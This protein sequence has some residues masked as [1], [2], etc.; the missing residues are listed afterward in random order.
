MRTYYLDMDERLTSATRFE[1]VYISV[2]PSR[3][4]YDKRLLTI[5]ASGAFI[6]HG[7]GL[8]VHG[9]SKLTTT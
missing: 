3:H 2:Q 6:C 4:T 7:F 9:T 5:R 8:T 1:I